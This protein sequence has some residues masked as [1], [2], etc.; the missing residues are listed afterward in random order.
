MAKGEGRAFIRETGRDAGT[1]VRVIR[2]RD[3]ATGAYFDKWF[4]GRNPKAAADKARAWREQ[5]GDSAPSRTNDITVVM[6][7][8]SYL[9]WHA[10]QVETSKPRL[11]TV[12]TLA[13][14]A[15]KIKGDPIAAVPLQRLTKQD[16]DE[17]IWRLQG[18]DNPISSSYALQV[19]SLLSRAVEKVVDDGHVARNVVVKS[20]KVRVEHKEREPLTAVEIDAITE[21][22]KS[23]S[24]RDYALIAVLRLGLRR[25][26]LTGLCWEDIELDI[27]KPRVRVRDQLLR[28]G[29]VVMGPLKTKEAKR[30]LKMKPGGMIVEALSALRAT[31]PNATGYVFVTKNGTPLDPSNCYHLVRRIGREAG[32]ENVDMHD[33][34]H[35]TSDTLHASGVPIAQIM[36]F[37]GH[38]DHRMTLATYNKLRAEDLDEAAAA[39]D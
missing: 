37:L 22:A 13:Y 27:E 39:L 23:R 21:V 30:T 11:H 4:T 1:A 10:A 25:G 12:E 14:T 24:T 7:I 17:M 2:V 6:A 5:H 18:G 38:K 34:R 28:G 3:P 35:W 36:R 20:A 29:R 16:V 19:R 31:R 32:I 8:E 26:E 9:R 33:F 15:R